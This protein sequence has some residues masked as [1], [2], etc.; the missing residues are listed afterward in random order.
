MP[1]VSEAESVKEKFEARKKARKAEEA[2]AAAEKAFQ[3]CVELC[4]QNNKMS[5]E[6]A[7]LALKRCRAALGEEEPSADQGL[8][9]DGLIR[10]MC[11]CQCRQLRGSGGGDDGGEEGGQEV[12]ALDHT[13][14]GGP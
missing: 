10:E 11:D 14:A 13:P 6:H 5:H 7:R 9:N 1:N 3:D 2:A 12:A 4:M 8:I